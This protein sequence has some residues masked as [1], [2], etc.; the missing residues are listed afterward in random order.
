MNDEPIQTGHR[1]ASG[2]QFQISH[3]D[4]SATWSRSA[5]GYVSTPS[6]G[7]S[8]STVIGRKTAAPELG[9]CR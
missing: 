5:V 1:P 4:Q 8:C 3:G 6:T 2:Q 7:S 9:D